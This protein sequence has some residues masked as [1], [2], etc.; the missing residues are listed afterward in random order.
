LGAGEIHACTATAPSLAF[1]SVT[2]SAD[3][4][5]LAAALH[6]AN[7]AAIARRRLKFVTMIPS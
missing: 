1:Q 5:M 3:A 7:R 6:T 2:A 4:V